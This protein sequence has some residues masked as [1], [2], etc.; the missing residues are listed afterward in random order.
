MRR[1][2]VLLRQAAARRAAGLHGLEPLAERDAA[3]DV[4]DDLAQRRAH[5]D[6]DQAR[7]DDLARQGEDLG[8]LAGLG[9]DG[10]EPVGA[11]Q[12]DDRDVG[13]GLDVVDDASAGRRAPRPPDTAAGAAA[14]RAPLDRVDQRRLLA[15]DE[16]AGAEP[17]LDVEREI[18]AQDVLAEQAVRPGILDGLLRIRLIASGYSARM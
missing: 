12:D 4:V 9:A 17:D 16:R 18:R 15:A 8:P 13:P 10:A 5:G 3:A 1:I 14:C 7:I 6:L 11:V 2:E